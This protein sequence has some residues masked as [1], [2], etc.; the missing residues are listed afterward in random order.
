MIHVYIRAFYTILAVASIEG[1]QYV[2]F[3]KY[4]LAKL[5]PAFQKLVHC[6]KGNSKI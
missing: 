5:I 4:R 2:D 1:L 3:G 6:P